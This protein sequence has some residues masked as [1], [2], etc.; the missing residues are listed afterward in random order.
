M[1]GVVWVVVLEV[2]SYSDYFSRIGSVWES[3]KTALAEKCKIETEQQALRDERDNW[4]TQRDRLWDKIQ[5]GPIRFWRFS[6]D[7]KKREWYAR[8]SEAPGGDR[9]DD[10]SVLEIPIGK[11]GCY[12]MTEN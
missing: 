5:P 8:L 2:G 12:W 4:C 7:A 9:W 11:P 6:S 10:V 1:S 3:E